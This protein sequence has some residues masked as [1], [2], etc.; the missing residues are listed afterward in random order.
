[1]TLVLASVAF[2]Y[3]YLEFRAGFERMDPALEEA[4]RMSGA[5]T[6]ARFSRR[7]LSAPLAIAPERHVPG[8]SLLALGFRCSRRFSGSPVREFVLTTL[9]YSQL[10]LGGLDGIENGLRALRA[11]AHDRRGGARAFLRT[12]GLSTPT[13]R[14]DR[15]REILAPFARSTRCSSRARWPRSPGAFSRSP[16]LCLGS[17]SECRRWRPWLAIRSRALDAQKSLLRPWTLGFPRGAIQF[18]FSH[19]LRSQRGIVSGGFL[20]RRSRPCADAPAGP[21]G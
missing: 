17:R 5:G 19:L 9:I 21:L 2:A 1:M 13:R 15:G 14:R 10:K 3:P 6:L 16:S 20:P 8:V 4:A 18:D 12:H 11:P 7:E